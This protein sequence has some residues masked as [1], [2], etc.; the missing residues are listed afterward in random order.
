MIRIVLLFSLL[1]LVSCGKPKT[2][3][4]CGDHICVNK[5]EAEEYFE[6]NLSIEVKIV[7]K[8]NEEEIDLVQL[9]LKGSSKH[10]KRIV[11]VQKKD[12]T[13]KEIKILNDSEVKKIKKDLKKRKSRNNKDK[14]VIK[15][16]N[17]KNDEK[18]IIKNKESSGLIADVCT[19]VKNCSIEDITKYLIEQGKN[20]KFPD[21]TIRE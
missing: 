2:V 7:D 11:S 13:D 4:I 21:L 10:N 18:I 8:K 12:R 16:N 19:I 9:N 1:Y 17:L 6:N 3:M 20:K 5:A 14:K 15:N